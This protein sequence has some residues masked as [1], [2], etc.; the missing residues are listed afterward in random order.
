MTILDIAPGPVV[1]RAWAH[2]KELRLDNG[3]MEREDAILAL[4]HWWAEQPEQ[5]GPD[6]PASRGAGAGN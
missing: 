6:G 2:M 4:K 1:G 3:P 5:A